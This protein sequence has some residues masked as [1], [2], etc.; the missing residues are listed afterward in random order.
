MAMFFDSLHMTD[1]DPRSLRAVFRDFQTN[2]SLRLD[3]GQIDRILG[4]DLEEVDGAEFPAEELRR[5]LDSL[6]AFKLMI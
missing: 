3:R 1:D 2:E 4:G 6:S 5:G